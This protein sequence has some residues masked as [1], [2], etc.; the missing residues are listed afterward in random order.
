MRFNAA[1]AMVSGQRAWESAS[2]RRKSAA[3]FT[4]LEMLI[5]LGIFAFAVIGL[6]MALEHTVDAARLTQ[7]EGAVRN[8]IENRL[9]RLSVGRL[10]PLVNE[11][12]IGGV[13]FFE[14]VDR[15]EMRSIENVELPGFWRISVTAQWKDPAG[16]QKWEASHLVFRNNE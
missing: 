3:G 2:L 1:A 15:E 6:M 5:A 13:T 9:A 12:T 16:E 4:L 8:G 7:R 14:K 10:R 11:E